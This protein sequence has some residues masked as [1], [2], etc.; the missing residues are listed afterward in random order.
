M[1]TGCHCKKIKCH[2][3]QKTNDHQ[4]NTG[5]IERQPQKE[6]VVYIGYDKLVEM[7]NFIQHIHLYEDEYNKPGNIF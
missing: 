6:E 2:P 5:N 7:R 1:K 4:T 3:G